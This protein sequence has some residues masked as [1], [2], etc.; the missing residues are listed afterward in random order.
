MPQT[1]RLLKLKEVKGKKGNNGEGKGKWPGKGKVEPDQSKKHVLCKYINQR[2]E[3]PTGG[4]QCA[5]S[6]NSKKFAK[7]K[8]KAKAKAAAG[9]AFGAPPPGLRM[10]CVYQ[11][12]VKNPFQ[13]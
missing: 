13:D 5:Y 10:V 1:I 7:G 2:E 11:D 4:A 9:G 12:S 3:C 8:P 6:R